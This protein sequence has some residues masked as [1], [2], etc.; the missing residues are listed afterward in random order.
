VIMSLI[1]YAQANGV[2]VSSL[3]HDEIL[4]TPDVP[5]DLKKKEAKSEKVSMK[6]IIAN[7]FLQSLRRLRPPRTRSS[8]SSPLDFY[9]DLWRLVSI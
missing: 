2:E 1:Q 4:I 9:V 6:N 8:A 3:I 5:L 7:V